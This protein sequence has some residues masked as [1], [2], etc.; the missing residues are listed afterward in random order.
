MGGDRAPVGEFASRGAA[1]AA[2][3]AAGCVVCSLL[4]SH[5]RTE[6]G[7]ER[8]LG[9]PLLQS[10]ETYDDIQNVRDGAQSGA[11]RAGA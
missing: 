8:L 3:T 1:E 11:E 7:P 2:A 10:D 9:A 6:N 5:A 4:R